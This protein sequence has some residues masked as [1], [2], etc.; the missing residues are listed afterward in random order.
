MPIT[1]SGFMA[2]DGA[3][4]L[5]DAWF[6][7]D[8]RGRPSGIIGSAGVGGKDGSGVSVPSTGKDSR[9]IW[10]SGILSGS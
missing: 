8:S 9:L 10:E 6:R 7:V 4:S 5:S 2:L 1:E 3:W